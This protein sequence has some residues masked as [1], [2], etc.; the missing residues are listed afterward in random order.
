[1]VSQGPNL[2]NGQYHTLPWNPWCQSQGHTH[3]GYTDTMSQT[4]ETQPVSV[5][6]SCMPHNI[7]VTDPM[8]HTLH[9]LCYETTQDHRVKHATSPS[10]PAC[11][12]TDITP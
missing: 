8:S 4:T 11:G 1:M 10:I 7:S 3:E 5:T 2:V 12:A 6:G 9:W